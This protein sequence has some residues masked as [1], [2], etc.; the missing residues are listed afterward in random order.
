MVLN[1]VLCKYM[2]N[3][4]INHLIH[5]HAYTLNHPLIS[6]EDYVSACNHA[7]LKA[8]KH[9]VKDYNVK[10]NT[11]AYYKY[12]KEIN[13]LN[14]QL[15]KEKDVMQYDSDIHEQLYDDSI[16][17][18]YDILSSFKQVVREFDDESKLLIVG[19]LVHGKTYNELSKTIGYS[20][21]TLGKKWKK[22]KP[23]LLKRM[24]SQMDYEQ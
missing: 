16:V 19:K 8:K 15:T 23:E 13:I 9:F 21:T 10:F 12:R 11:Y 7:T 2:N 20:K 17:K 22:I 14:K 1:L 4:F 6:K 5:K 24:R 3:S 18:N